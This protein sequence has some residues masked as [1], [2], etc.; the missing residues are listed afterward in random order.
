MIWRP[1]Y[2][3][4][5]V[6]FADGLIIAFSFVAAY[7][8]WQLVKNTFPW[9]PLGREMEISKDSFWKIVIFSIIWVI[10]LT[11]LNAYNNQRFTS[12]RREMKLVVKTSLVGTF[13]IFAADFVFRFEYIPRTYIGI[14]F[15]VNLFS[16][17]VGKIIL[18]RVAKLIRERGKDRKQVLLVGANEKAREFIEIVN[19]NIGW[20]L[21]IIGLISTD[22]VMQ[23][24]F[25]CGVKFLGPYTDIENIL[26]QHPIDEVIIFISMQEFPNIEEI[27]KI[28]ER[29]GV[30]VRVN[31]DFFRRLTKRVTVDQVYGVTFISLLNVS[32]SEWSE[33]IKRLMDI[34]LS[35]IGIIM[36]SP[37]FLLISILIKATSKGPVFHKLKVFGLNK[38]PYIMYKFRTMVINAEEIK[39]R[40]IQLNEMKGP[41]FKIKDD[42]RITKLGKYLRKYSLDELPQ[43]WNVL[44]GEM[45]LVGP[46]Q[47]LPEELEKYGSWHRRKLSVKPGITCL[48]QVS[49]R[50]KIKDFDEW[51]KMDLE[52]IDNWSLWLD[53]KILFKTLITVVKGTG[54]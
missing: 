40:L 30:Q 5:I 37:L 43:L 24:E 35:A 48:W 20:G 32:R 33:I 21:D 1:S 23:E 4:K 42:P 47:A 52:Y 39:S 7:F 9:A 18:F 6:Q 49:G 12:I 34:F 25:I 16:L 36:L 46:R 31:S 17:S 2:H 54:Y 22:S 44:K 38:K 14:F 53:I 10:I 3:K 11:K 19:K 26:H 50:N 8:L 41:V 29:E 13:I 28:C 15:V 45:S 51:V 27:I